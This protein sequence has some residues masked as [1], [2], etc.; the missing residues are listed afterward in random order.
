[1]PFPGVALIL[2]LDTTGRN[3]VRSL[4]H[5]VIPISYDNLG[6]LDNTLQ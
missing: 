5:F 3:S 2:Q 4:T 6:S 1:M